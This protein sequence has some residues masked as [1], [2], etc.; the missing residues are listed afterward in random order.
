M[1]WRVVPKGS[2]LLGSLRP[3]QRVVVA[4]VAGTCSAV[5]EHGRR[6]LSTAAKAA[7][8]QPD[9]PMS[10]PAH[11]HV[12]TGNFFLDNPALFG[13]LFVV[14]TCSYFY[15]NKRGNDART[16]LIDSIDADAAVSPR[17]IRQL[18]EDNNIT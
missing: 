4:R 6:R 15:Y 3:L 7:K 9:T 11:Q 17:E 14:C 5:R 10:A 1:M 2:R 8:K 18:R 16:E 12:D 13:S